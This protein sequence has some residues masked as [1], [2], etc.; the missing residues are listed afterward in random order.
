[1]S[2]NLTWISRK[3]K[4]LMSDEKFAHFYHL[5]SIGVATL[6]RFKNRGGHGEWPMV[7]DHVALTAVHLQPAICFVVRI[8]A[9]SLMTAQSF[10]MSPHKFLWGNNLT[11]QNQK[12][13]GFLADRKAKHQTDRQTWP[14]FSSVGQFVRQSFFSNSTRV[15]LKTFQ[16]RFLKNFCSSKSGHEEWR[17]VWLRSGKRQVVLWSTD[18]VLGSP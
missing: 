15:L 2:R 8:L 18:S 5:D 6:D 3:V 4:R 9:K 7:T 17:F 11:E 16:C 13:S 14:S 12:V 10:A 1:M